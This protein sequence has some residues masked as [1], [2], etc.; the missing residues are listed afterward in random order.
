MTANGKLASKKKESLCSATRETESIIAENQPIP[1]TGKNRKQ[2]RVKREKKCCR[3]KH[4]KTE[5]KGSFQYKTSFDRHWTDQWPCIISC[6]ESK[7]CFYCK[8]CKWTVSCRKQG[9]HHVKVHIETHMHQDNAKGIKNQST[10]FQVYASTQNK[11]DKVYIIFCF[12]N[13]IWVSYNLYPLL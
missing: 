1:S 3:W 11:Q 5:H 8:V 2:N 9:I 7:H 12:S 13:T 6:P 4:K 10:L